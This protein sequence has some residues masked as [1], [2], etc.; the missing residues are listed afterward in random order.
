M[1][2]QNRGPG[3]ITRSATPRQARPLFHKAAKDL[4]DLPEGSCPTR[5]GTGLSR[6]CSASGQGP[7]GS[8]SRGESRKG[9]APCSPL[10]PG[11]TDPD[12]GLQW[13]PR[14]AALPCPGQ[15]DTSGPS[16]AGSSVPAARRSLPL[17][18]HRGVRGLGGRRAPRPLSA[19]APGAPRAGW[20]R[21]SPACR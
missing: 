15:R 3:L 6:R 4:C 18:E 2:R 17:A 20:A 12:R 16:G 5:E 1:T 10:P 13:T 21:D 14:S 8:P 11:H 19:R 9:A 7:V